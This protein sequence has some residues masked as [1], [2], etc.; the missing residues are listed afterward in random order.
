MKALHIPACVFLFFPQAL[1]VA[2][3]GGFKRKLQG[4][5]KSIFGGRFLTQRA[6]PCLVCGMAAA[7][8]RKMRTLRRS[9]SRTAEDPRVSDVM[10]ACCSGE[11]APASQEG[12][13]PRE[14]GKLAWKGFGQAHACAMR[15][16]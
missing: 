14:V 4:E 13:R 16:D 9:E 12:W 1:K 5:R 8:C 10:F 2:Y 11:E 6:R 15:G 3:W 7:F